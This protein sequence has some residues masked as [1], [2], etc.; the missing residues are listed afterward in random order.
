MP[1]KYDLK[2]PKPL[3]SIPRLKSSK[4]RIVQRIDNGRKQNNISKIHPIPN[5][6][7]DFEQMIYQ[8][9]PRDR[10]VINRIMRFKQQQKI[11]Q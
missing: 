2:V 8:D 6:L 10:F 1:D 9:K 11:S 3:E 5:Q 7:T 4:L